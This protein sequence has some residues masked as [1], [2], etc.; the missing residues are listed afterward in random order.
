M[1]WL[2]GLLAWLTPA[3]A[4]RRR[5][6]A[7][8]VA[9]WASRKRLA[10]A[11]VCG[12][13]TIR[14]E[15]DE[16]EFRHH[17]ARYMAGDIDWIPGPRTGPLPTSLYPRHAWHERIDEAPRP[18][19]CCVPSKEF[20]AC[21][22]HARVLGLRV[23]P[24]MFRHTWLVFCPR[25]CTD[26]ELCPWRE[27]LRKADVLEGIVEYQGPLFRLPTEAEQ[28][29]DTGFP[30]RCADTDL[31]DEHGHATGVYHLNPEVSFR[32]LL[33]GAGVAGG[34]YHPGAV[35]DGPYG[36]NP[37]AHAGTVDQPAGVDDAECE[38]S[39]AH[40]SAQPNPVHRVV[41]A[42]FPGDSTQ[43]PAER[44]A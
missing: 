43:R 33:G 21:A 41:L 10:S 31:I 34:A 5:S 14:C 11:P 15:F 37:E 40:P 18:T 12:G 19:I 3:R 26:V 42:G 30:A 8:S 2:D 38:A 9:R 39:D 23:D 32:L 13:V 7:E 17:F 25:G 22:E 16:D 20:M 29:A 4:S 28:A 1:N 6:G 36:G 24:A 27:L 44:A 35:I